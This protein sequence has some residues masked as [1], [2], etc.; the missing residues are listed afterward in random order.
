[1]SK[2]M[3]RGFDSI[4]VAVAD[5]PAPTGAPYRKMEGQCL[6]PAR[7]KVGKGSFGETLTV[8]LQD[9]LRVRDR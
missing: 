2:S 1:M 8:A 3:F 5:A 9:M 7:R 4:E 6:L